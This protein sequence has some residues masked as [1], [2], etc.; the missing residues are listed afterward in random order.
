MRYFAILII[1][2]ISKSGVVLRSGILRSKVRLFLQFL[3]EPFPDEK[4]YVIWGIGDV[5][6]VSLVSCELVKQQAELK[7][8]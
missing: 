6:M 1:V 7:C 3:R 2:F 8:I 4:L 5:V